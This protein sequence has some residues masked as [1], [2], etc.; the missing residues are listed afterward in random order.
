M[1]VGEKTLR[2]FYDSLARCNADPAFLDRF[3]DIFLSRSPKVQEK[4]VNTDFTKQKAALRASFSAMV[5]AAAEGAPAKY[6][7]KLANRHSSR[8][9]DIGSEFYDLWLDSLIEAARK[10]DPEFGF[11][12][13]KAWE[14]VM[15]VG[16][17][18]LLSRY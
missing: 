16:I 12:V 2:T 18:Y 3:Y 8:D 14:A 13:A 11:D 15:M 10:T 9:L 1:P 6:L 4:F 5:A 17:D 7:D